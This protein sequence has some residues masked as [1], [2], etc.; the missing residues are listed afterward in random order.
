MLIDLARDRDPDPM[1]AG[2]LPDFPA[3]IPLVAHKAMGPTFGAATPHPS[4]CSLRQQLGEDHGFVPLAWRQDQGQEL[5]VPFRAEVDCGAK[6][7]L[8]AP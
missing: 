2:I 5:A 7:A 4:D 6:T 3:A 1:A 8:A